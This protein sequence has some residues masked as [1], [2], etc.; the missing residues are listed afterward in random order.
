MRT[1]GRSPR[2]T[3]AY[4]LTF[5]MPRAF[6]HSSTEIVKVLSFVWRCRVSFTVV[7]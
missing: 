7:E 6:A 1:V 3:A 4:A 5:D 2:L